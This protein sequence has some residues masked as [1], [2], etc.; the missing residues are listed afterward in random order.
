MTE[1]VCPTESATYSNFGFLLKVDF[2]SCSFLVGCVEELGLEAK[3]GDVTEDAL[4]GGF[5]VDLEFAGVDDGNE[6]ETVTGG[7]VVFIWGFGLEFD[8]TFDGNEFE[9]VTGGFAV[10]ILGLGF[11]FDATFVRFSIFLIL[12]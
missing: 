10:F 9:I 12:V 8:A 6:F 5:M 2:N 7:F 1:A 11:E 3:G 4:E